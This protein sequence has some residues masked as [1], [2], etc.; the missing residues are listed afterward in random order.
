MATPPLS[1][2]SIL[3]VEGKNNTASD[4]RSSLIALGA[5]VHVVSNAEAGVM[6]AR[7]KRLHGAVLDCV[8]QGAS[9]SLCVEL[10]QG[11]VPF[12]FYGGIAGS[13]ADEAASCISELIS[14][15]NSRS[16]QKRRL[17]FHGSG[18]DQYQAL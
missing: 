8:S 16:P 11:N 13:S 10:S 17:P 12:M 14:I 6:I 5:G 2:M 9:Q 4:L 15:E 1:G 3:V 18:E 7:R